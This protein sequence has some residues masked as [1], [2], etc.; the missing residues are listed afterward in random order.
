MKSKILVV[1]DE[2]DL[3][4]ELAPMLERAGYSVTTAGDGVQALRAVEQIKPELV[5][6]DVMMPRMSGMA[7]LVQLKSN[8]PAVPVI[9]ITGYGGRFTPQEAMGAGADGYF[10]K[11][12]KN[13][14]LIRTLRGVL[15]TSA[16]VRKSAT[17]SVRR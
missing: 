1:D 17:A 13:V 7:L 6:L 2:A 15:T 5:V 8:Y 4:A 16:A 9:L 3:L 11:P 10:L 14:E 12:F